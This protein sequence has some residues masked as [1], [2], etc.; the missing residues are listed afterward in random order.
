MITIT[1]ERNNRGEKAMSGKLGKRIFVA[2]YLAMLISGIGYAK[3]FK[4]G[5]SAGYLMMQDA[6]YEEV[7]SS[8]GLTY[9]ISLGFQ[10]FDWM[11]VRGE[12]NIF[13]QNGEL[14]L[15]QE[16]TKFSLT[17]IVVGVRALLMKRKITPYIGLGANI[18]SYKESLP[19]R[20][21]DASGSAIGFHGEGGAYYNIA[22]GFY[23]DLSVRYILG[24]KA[25][26]T[27]AGAANALGGRTEKAK[28]DGLRTSIGF[29]LNF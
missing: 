10:I 27:D 6:R 9:G 18:I 24:A 8:G 2:L 28:L 4:L 15:T 3:G 5:A 19:A 16:Q 20:M 25:D 7:Y 12:F 13:Q 17:P 29:G 21:G 26:I 11:E 22:K 1:K 14:I 23:V